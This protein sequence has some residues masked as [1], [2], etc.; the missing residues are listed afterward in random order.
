LT[1]DVGRD[2]GD[3]GRALLFALMTAMPE[4]AAWFLPQ[5]LHKNRENNPM[6]R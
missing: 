2:R 3:A 4:V 5:G 1:G 6:H